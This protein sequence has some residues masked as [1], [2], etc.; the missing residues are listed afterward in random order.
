LE[1]ALQPGQDS[2]GEHPVSLQDIAPFPGDLPPNN[3]K[4]K[5][6][7]LSFAFDDAPLEKSG[8]LIGRYR[9][10]QI[11]GDGGMGTVWEAEQE[12]PVRRRVA[13]KIIKLGMDT[14]EIVGRFEAERQALA[15]MDHPNIAKV[16]DGG[17]TATGRPYFVMELVRGKPITTYCNE[18]RLPISERL[19][20]FVGACAAV[21]HAHQKS[22]VHRDI[23][24]SNIM[25]SV[26][27]RV[28]L[29]K[30]IDFGIAKAIGGQRLTAKTVFT[31]ME[32]F[33]GTPAYA[34]PE[35]ID[36]SSLDIDTRTDIY[37]LGVLLYELLTG[38]TPFAD[39]V[40]SGS[41]DAI[42]R[43]VC[44]NE[45][46][47][48]SVQIGTILA[49]DRAVAARFQ[50][51]PP[52]LIHQ[53]RGDLDWIVLKCLEK[54]RTRRYDTVN[55][56]AQDVERHLDLRPVEASPPSTVYRFQRMVR[57]H[58]VSFAA[59]TAI[60]ILLVTGAV[61]ETWQAH[62]QKRLRL[63]AE[64]AQQSA[65]DEAARSREVAQFLENMLEGVDPAVARGHDT[66]ILR[67]ILDQTTQR[68][69]GL[70]DE[71][72]VAAELCTTIGNVYTA[73]GNYPA[74][75]Q[76]HRQAL[77]ARQKL[78]GNHDF[79]IAGSLANLG[80]ALRLEGKLPEADDCYHSALAILKK[81]FGDNDPNVA[82]AMNNL[83]RA[84][85]AEGRLAEAEEIERQALAM[86]R[87]LLGDDDP[88]VAVSASA[89]AT[90]LQEE[91]KLVEADFLYRRALKLRKK[92][93]GGKD[94][95]T[96][97]TMCN[98]ATVLRQEAKL[99]DA[100]KLYQEALDLYH[101]LLG[102]EHPI[103]ATT[104]HNLANVYFDRGQ[105]AEAETAHR[106]ALEMRRKVLPADHP[107]IAESLDSLATVLGA[108]NKGAEAESLYS[109][110]L[111]IQE[112]ELGR[113][114]PSVATTL[115]NMADLMLKEG[116][117]VASEDLYRRSLAIRERAL[118]Q[119]WVTFNARSRLGGSLLEQR[120]FAEAEPLLVYG[121][122]GMNKRVSTI[123]TISRVFLKEAA[124]R[125]ARL[126]EATGRSAKAAEW[127]K[128]ADGSS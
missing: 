11:L 52:K 94:P 107:D 72:D 1:Q 40:K 2:E 90:V 97:T 120:R 22:I 116:K 85:L 14:K 17:V 102:P 109:E 4:A 28:P 105:L 126:Y 23:K 98:L 73:L 87:K 113:D 18:F 69:A 103:I 112:N 12:E 49:M 39:E 75:E 16:L 128:K 111:S 65:R 86:R 45:P 83:G 93:S 19:K 62:V 30:V 13:L 61:L 124:E 66:T 114:H 46:L 64:A 5:T 48:P 127:K 76:M 34:S 123:P 32:Q 118:P 74:A 55:S 115:G 70:Q 89:L 35:Q 33:I 51:D 99:D 24:P 36:S 81:L 122:E 60:A 106:Q 44:D 31:E 58:K 25:V 63:E 104:L 67:S 71:P 100:Q 57:R 50:V 101:E 92:L 68:L 27:D 117:A 38:Q 3:K 9:L 110:A 8:M 37:S 79:D 10:I 95:A 26:P 91:G 42:R 125:L 54:D 41:L 6:I 15:M 20:L 88:A 47:R 80:D 82:T 21:Q 53:I 7:A 77:A 56:L 78:S 43:A 29:P 121:W 84:F 59:A 119:S 108:E 96:T